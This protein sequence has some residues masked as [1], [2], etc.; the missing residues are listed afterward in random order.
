MINYVA[1][2]GAVGTGTVMMWDGNLAGSCKQHHLLQLPSWVAHGTH[3]SLCA[4]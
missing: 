2:T 1:C 3:R 4:C